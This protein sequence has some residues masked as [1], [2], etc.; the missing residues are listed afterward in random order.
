[1]VEEEPASIPGRAGWLSAG[2]GRR[3]RWARSRSLTSFFQVGA[4]SGARSGAGPGTGWEG[5]VE[6]L[7]SILAKY[8]AVHRRNYA[9][10]RPSVSVSRATAKRGKKAAKTVSAGPPTNA[11]AKLRIRIYRSLTNL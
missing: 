8:A 2:R 5:R 1:M 11:A 6:V 7:N 3:V 10:K 9:G 4:T